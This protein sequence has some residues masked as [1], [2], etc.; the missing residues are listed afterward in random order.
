M[1]VEL[2][3]TSDASKDLL[4]QGLRLKLW[5]VLA[6][7]LRNFT[8]LRRLKGSVLTVLGTSL[9]LRCPLMHVCLGGS[10][11]QTSAA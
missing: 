3:R 1:L 8:G 6:Q 7:V 5:D 2:L 9:A 11:S 4:G 10:L